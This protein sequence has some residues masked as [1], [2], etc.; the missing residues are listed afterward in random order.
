MEI[1]FSTVKRVLVIKLRHHG[2]VLLSTP[3]FSL[4]KSRIPNVQIDGYV[5]SECI[6][7]LEGHPAISDLIGYD[8]K[9]KKGGLWKR[10]LG[11]WRVLKQIRKNK[12]DLVI[13]LTE[14]DRGAIV[15]AFS[16]ARYRLGMDP[17]KTGMLFKKKLFTHLYQR[18]PTLRHTVEK[19][20]DA[21]RAIGLMPRLNEKELGFFVPE[22]AKQTVDQLTGSG[23]FVH[24][25]PSSRWDF[26]CVPPQ[27]M[28]QVIRA[29]RQRGETVVISS[30]PDPVEIAQVEEIL[31]RSGPE[32][33]INMAGK[34][35]LKELGAFIS[36]AKLL[37]CVDSLP[38][39]LSSVFK[40][41]VVVLFGPSSYVN[42]GPWQNARARVIANQYSCQPCYLPGCGASG[43]SEC[44]INLSP[45]ETIAQ[46]F[47]LLDQ[48]VAAEKVSPR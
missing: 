36:K 20:L 38:L 9:W 42:W 28:A 16:K 32:G 31:A 40:A 13:S 15:A 27:H 29:L 21:M 41:P 4:L 23:G 47:E 26:K 12:Y 30:G 37:I 46:A 2:D 7:I 6:P 1:D 14:G 33:V 17:K 22:Q 48:A 3:V 25:H 8:K 18:C 39:H 44:L 11:E 43:K 35:S 34:M 10:V 5:Y 45:K 19:D 24:I